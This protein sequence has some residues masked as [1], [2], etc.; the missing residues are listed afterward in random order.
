MKQNE[1]FISFPLIPEY[2]FRVQNLYIV[3]KPVD[4]SERCNGY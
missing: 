3:G 4:S 2:V 1:T